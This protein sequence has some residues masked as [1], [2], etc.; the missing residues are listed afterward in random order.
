[1]TIAT[2]PTNDRREL[3]TATAAQTVFPFD[4][5]MYAQ[6]DLRVRRTRAGVAV[7]LTLGSDY[8]VTG[9]GNQAG[10]SITFTTG[11]L[12]GDQILVE[13][14]MPTGRTSAFTD[15]GDL[16]AAAL[17]S[18]F[19]RIFI[20]L[21]Q[22]ERDGA[23]ALQVDA[24]ETGLTALPP[25]VTRA[26]KLLGFDASGNPIAV[27]ATAGPNPATVTGFMATV[28]DDGDAQTARATLGAAAAVN[29]LYGLASASTVDLGQ[30]SYSEA[31]EITGTVT[32]TSFGNAAP[33]LR[34]IVRF[35]GTPLLTANANIIL[36]GGNNI[37][38]V[39]FD[40]AEFISLGASVWVCID[41]Q[42]YSGKALDET[43]ARA[44][45]STAQAIGYGGQTVFAHGL[46]GMPQL[47]QMRLVCLG[48]EHG[49]SVGDEVLIEATAGADGGTSANAGP[50]HSVRITAT[51][52]I[53]RHPSVSYTLAHATTGATVNLTATNWA[54][55]ARA[56]R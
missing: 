20:T 5:P 37:Q 12:A 17:N 4:F 15:G 44:Y 33:G 42:R 24:A 36:P 25:V 14:A 43:F 26:N 47:V 16:P 11:A 1:M 9:A 10:G 53:V 40:W 6:T 50:L 30:W 39:A 32:I 28:L 41:Y 45:L 8:T 38:T 22:Q 31:V 54:I 21:Q 51:Q 3:Y 35:N 18:E 52:I 56:W 29:Q 19:N 23:R 34:R 55:V 13:S 27:A 49:Y 7:T 48:V 46:G 2:I